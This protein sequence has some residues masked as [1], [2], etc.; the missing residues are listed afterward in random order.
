M[1]D[2]TRQTKRPSFFEIIGPGILIAATGVGAGDLAI[3]TFSGSKLGTAV[4]WAVLV[5][6]VLKFVLTEGL[7]RWQ[8]A[9]GKTLLEG[10]AE[11]LS[12]IVGWLFLPY[13]LVW[14]FYVGAALMSANGI[15]IH[16]M[17]PVFSD[18]ADAKIV[19][20]ILASLVGLG[21]VL[22]GGF[23]LFEK[24]MGACIALMFSSVVVTAILLWPGTEAVL[25]GLFIPSIPDADGEGLTWTVALMGGVGGTLTILCYGYWIREKNRYG[26][27]QLTVCRIDLGV[28]WLVTIVFGLAMV[29]VGTSVQIEGTGADLLVV[30][31]DQLEMTI[32]PVGKWIFL[33]GAFGAVFSSLLGVWQAVPYLF[34]DFW[35]L[36]IVRNPESSLSDEGTL[37]LRNKPYRAY[38]YAIAFIPIFGL[39]VSFKEIQILYTT[40]G[41][42][43]L[44]LLALGLLIL[45][46]RK[47]WIGASTN[48]PITVISLVATLVFFGWLAWKGWVGA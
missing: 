11:R 34:A 2:P 31:S 36:F 33:L 5:G 41:A 15:A 14:S 21:L 47:K 32:G 10:A 12:P 29:I 13:L 48:R 17:V 40:I 42:A 45:N 20:G 8:L 23:S 1:P 19:F 4:L 35:R 27:D 28:G 3:A 16:A 18:P 43:F 22:V 26:L 46:G 7:T 6:G 44:P 9:T 38:L 37:N 25:S 39:F 24:I 30:L